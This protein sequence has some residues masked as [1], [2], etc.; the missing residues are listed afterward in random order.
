M[1]IAIYSD[2]HL[3]TLRRHPELARVPTPP[4]DTDLIILAGDIHNGTAGLDALAAH[5]AGHIYVAGNHEYYKHDIEILDHQL[6]HRAEQLGLNFLQCN[7]LIR[8]DI[9][10]L[11]TTLWTD[12]AIQPAW[13]FGAELVAKAF[14][15]D[16]KIIRLRGKVF[17]PKAAVALHQ[18][19]LEWLQSELHKPFD[20]KTV[21]ITHH[22][23]HPL[24]IHPRFQLSP[25]NA[26]FVSD[27]TP[28]V[29]YADVWIHGHMHDSFNYQLDNARKTR[30]LV[31]PRGYLRKAPKHGRPTFENMFFDKQCVLEI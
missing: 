21:V 3:E 28:L 31:N 27:L 6:R 15:P 23:P 12:F 14:L 11:G 1:K 24:S 29:G 9:R 5:G 26:A 8:D 17:S 22:A 7:V 18:S 13:R 25:I 2:L 16:F 30:V 19:N 10:F 4:N 20:G